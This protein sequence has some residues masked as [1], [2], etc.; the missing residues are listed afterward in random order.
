MGA[1]GKELITLSLEHPPT[2]ISLVYA[3]IT[4]RTFKRNYVTT[5]V[6]RLSKRGNGDAFV[7][8]LE[9]KI[10]NCIEG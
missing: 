7:K 5:V 1:N 10:N 6:E 8:A 2:W 3:A 4:Q 9:G